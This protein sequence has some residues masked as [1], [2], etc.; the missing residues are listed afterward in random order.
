[1]EKL[2]KTYTETRSKTAR[3]ALIEAYIPLVHH[4]VTKIVEKNQKFQIADDLFEEGVIGLMEAIEK[5]DPSRGLKF[6]TYATPRIFGSMVD[7][8]RRTYL[9]QRPPKEKFAP[10]Y[11]E[12]VGDAPA[13]TTPVE[14]KLERIEFL[15]TVLK[16]ESKRTRLILIALYFEGETMK[17]TGKNVGVSESRVS[18]IVQE[19][20]GRIRERLGSYQHAINELN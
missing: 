10:Q 13:K 1:M 6:S 7:A 9:T 3:N 14:C 5:F 18:Q 16:G 20:F 12:H 19:T 15:Q 2:W 17:S 8:M 11:V 4:V